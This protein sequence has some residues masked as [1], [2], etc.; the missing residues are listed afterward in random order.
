MTRLVCGVTCADTAALRDDAGSVAWH[1]PSPG[2]RDLGFL[3][4][5]GAAAEALNLPPVS[6]MRLVPVKKG[7]HTEHTSMVHRM[8]T[9][10]NGRH[11][12]PRRR[13]EDCVDA[14]AGSRVEH[15]FALL[16]LGQKRLRPAEAT[17]RQPDAHLAAP[18][19]NSKG[20]TH[21]T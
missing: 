14:A 19:G 4:L 10:F 7:W 8:G 9:D 5:L 21:L 1:P 18:P 20:M 2:C 16:D 13:R 17:C 3:R 11:V 15:V 12:T 6:T